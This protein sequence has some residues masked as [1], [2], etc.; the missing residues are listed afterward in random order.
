MVTYAGSGHII[1]LVLFI[2]GARLDE[3]VCSSG[4]SAFLKFL[5]A[6]ELQHC[7][8]LIP[9]FATAVHHGKDK[10][11]TAYEN[12]NEDE[13]ICAM[14]EAILDFMKPEGVS[15]HTSESFF[16]APELRACVHAILGDY[17]TM[18]RLTNTRQHRCPF[19]WF[20]RG[21][22]GETSLKT[23]A[24]ERE[25]LKKCRDEVMCCCIK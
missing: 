9:I 6:G 2:D 20:K 7:R 1:R 5:D 15:V 8:Q 12:A 23:S 22:G 24:Q 21:E 19:C 3:F 11:A 14:M 16:R 13:Y 18:I 4:E 10:D 17:P 25:R